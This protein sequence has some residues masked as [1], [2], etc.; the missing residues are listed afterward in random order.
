[1][2]RLLHYLLKDNYTNHK[3]FLRLLFS[4]HCTKCFSLHYFI[5]SSKQATEVVAITDAETTV[6]R[7]QVTRLMPL[8]SGTASLQTLVC[9]PQS[10]CS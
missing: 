4:K 1:M 10:P 6:E 3:Y 9:F 2:L 5:Y 8:V 7:G